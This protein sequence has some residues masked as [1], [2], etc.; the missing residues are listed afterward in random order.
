MAQPST[1]TQLTLHNSVLDPLKPYIPERKSL[2][3]FVEDLL[4][5]QLQTIDNSF[6]LDER[7]SRPQAGSPTEGVSPSNSSFLNKRNKENDFSLQ[8]EEAHVPVKA[9]KTIKTKPT[10]DIAQNLW[11][12]E[13]LIR[14]YWKAKPKN[15]TA[16]AWKL[17]MTELTK[18]QDGYGDAALRTQL[19]LAEA[20]R[21]QGI[22]LSN[23][24]RFGL[25][26]GNAPAQGGVDWAE[27]DRLTFGGAA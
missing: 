8:A 16:P 5:K 15:K 25:P 21:W 24:E 19:E 20:N 26:K 22:T 1:R 14:A 12:H 17:L 2:T 23:Y 3:Q 10:F 13:D 27:V 18:I 4:E 9:V 6:T 7:P 11:G